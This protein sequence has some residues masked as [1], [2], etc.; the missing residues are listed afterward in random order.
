MHIKAFSLFFLFVRIEGD[1]GRT[2]KREPCDFVTLKS[3]LGLWVNKVINL[4]FAFSCFSINYY[5]AIMSN[6]P[7]WSWNYWKRRA[8]LYAISNSFEIWSSQSRYVLEFFL[9]HE[10]P[11]FI[12]STNLCIVIF[13]L[14]IFK[15]EC[16]H[17]VR[18]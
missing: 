16:Y 12:L 10:I 3:F 18:H 15:S 2:K 9:Y 6:C 11:P 17:C 5:L 14:I 1:K 8:C 13:P 4:P 7:W